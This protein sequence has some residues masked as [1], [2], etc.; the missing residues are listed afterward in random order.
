MRAS[1]W[2]VHCLYMSWR[3]WVATTGCGARG[4]RCA[5]ACARPQRSARR[6]CG[7]APASICNC[8][9]RPVTHGRVWLHGTDLPR[10]LNHVASAPLAL[11]HSN[12]NTF[13]PASSQWSNMAEG[14]LT[15]TV[16]EASGKNK[17]DNFVWDSDNFEGYVK[18]GGAR[19]RGGQALHSARQHCRCDNSPSGN[20]RRGI[21]ISAALA[22]MSTRSD[23]D[24][25]PLA[26]ELR[27]GPRNVKVSTRRAPVQGSTIFWNEPLVL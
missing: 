17:D 3:F 21:R 15:M 4:A 16:I 19:A 6:C 8:S 12:R 5:V 20:P 26:V 22:F 7:A 11:R 1:A 18:G 24:A 23:G 2:I 9:D 14:F 13:A 25:R 10:R 27:G